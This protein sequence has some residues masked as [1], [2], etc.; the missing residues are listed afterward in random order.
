MPV[1][2]WEGTTKTGEKKSGQTEGLNE[3]F[4]IALLKKQEI[5]V[6]SIKK[7]AQM[8]LDLSGLSFGT[9]VGTKD[10]VVFTRQ[11]A[12]MINAGL[13]LVTCLDIL[14]NQSDNPALKK[15][16]LQVKSDVEG[17][18]T[19]AD[20]L[21]KHPKVF[22]DLFVNLVAA[23]EIGG[24]LDTIMNRLAAYIEKNEKIVK[25]V[26]GAMTYPL[27][28]LG[29]A[30]VLVI[31]MLWKVIP[32][33]E[34]M[35]KDF[36][37]ELPAPTQFVIDLSNAF[38]NHAFLIVGSLVAFVVAFIMF[39]KSKPG[40][41]IF[42]RILIQSPVFGDIIRKSAVAKFTR[43]MSTMIS[44]GVPILDGLNIVARAAGNVVVEKAIMYTRDKIS[45]GKNIAEPMMETKVFPP[46]VV[47][48]IA[49]GEAT[50]AMD[51]MMSKIADFY[52][53]EVDTAVE[54]MTS[55]LEPIIMIFLAI[56]AGGLVVSM[57]LPIFSVAGAI[58]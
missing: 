1:F 47:Q 12:T 9:G 26:K 57:Y 39:Y 40:K 27:V 42:D 2:I 32:M 6:T 24:I 30:I 13:P 56:V 16:L 18:S 48:M 14:G 23:G 29:V 52:E 37:G 55:L 38:M 10:L 49:V 31:G 58:K 8:K 43:T 19:F 44:S 35:F 21:R 5:Q 51:T 11:F 46:M 4:V 36:G 33:F 25:K 28:V 20:A 45:E 50:G 53:D 54:T 41:E 34:K 22:D 7:K 17:G 15:I 3:E